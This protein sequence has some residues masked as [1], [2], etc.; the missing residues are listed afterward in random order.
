MADLAR[1][2]GE[3]RPTAVGILE[4]LWHM[5]SRSYRTGEIT[6]LDSTDLAAYLGWTKDPNALIQALIDSR[7]LDA[8]DDCGGVFIHDWPDHCEDSVRKT[9]KNNKMAFS[10]H[11]S[12]CRDKNGTIQ[13]FLHFSGKVPKEPD[14]SGKDRL[15]MP[16]PKPKPMPCAAP[17]PAPTAKPATPPAAA[18]IAAGA[19]SRKPS[20][21][22]KGK[23]KPKAEPA[24][25]K[26]FTDAWCKE[27]ERIHKAKYPFQTKDGVAAATIW[28]YT[29]GDVRSAMDIAVNYLMEPD[30]FY[31]GHPLT[32]LAADLP[33]FAAIDPDGIGDPNKA[34][35]RA[36]TEA[37][38]KMLQEP[39]DEGTNGQ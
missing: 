20:G 24:P 7:W 29:H 38:L 12:T 5:A 36:P 15:P 3:M 8:C 4:S 16:L 39:Y 9:L 33:R 28:K 18:K 10:G 22:P 26:Q 37:E 2:L 30:K 21:K 19:V 17:A 27:W 23:A 35:G 13:T 14:V 6:H 25:F 1:L 31:T 32:K 34:G 11:Y